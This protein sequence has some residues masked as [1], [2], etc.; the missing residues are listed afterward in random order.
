MLQNQVTPGI[1]NSGFTFPQHKAKAPTSV[2]YRRPA[3]DHH[4]N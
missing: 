2:V 3:A 1:S 4:K